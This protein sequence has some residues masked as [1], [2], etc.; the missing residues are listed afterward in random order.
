MTMVLQ[1]ANS[2][3]PWNQY[4]QNIMLFDLKKVNG[5]EIPDNNNKSFIKYTTTKVLVVEE[6]K[7]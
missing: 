6:K 5:I 4:D 3:T 1:D 2:I 7:A